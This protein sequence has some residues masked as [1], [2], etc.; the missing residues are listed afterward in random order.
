MKTQSLL[1][2]LL[3]IFFLVTACKKSEN[4]STVNLVKKEIKGDFSEIEVS[5]AIMAEVVKSDVERVVLTAPKDLMEDIAVTNINGVLSLKMKLKNVLNTGRNSPVKATIY[6]TDFNS[7]KASSSSVINVRDKF[8]GEGMQITASSSAVISGNLE[9]N[10]FHLTTNSSGIFKGNIWAINFYSE[11][12]SS[13]TTKVTGK[14]TTANVNSSS[15]SIFDGSDFVADD[16]TVNASSS[17]SV[18]IGV[19]NNFNATAS[20]SANIRYKLMGGSLRQI[21]YQENSG[22]TV[23]KLN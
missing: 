19:R 3:T 11:N 22:G 2:C 10:E 12:S 9:A 14:T 5:N 8:L 13:S 16:A 20:S 6:A 15:S 23:K 7:L 1:T 21:N 4:E 18:R 17:S